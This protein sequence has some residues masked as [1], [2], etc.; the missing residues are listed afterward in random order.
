M[1]RIPS[2]LSVKPLWCSYTASD[3]PDCQPNL[4]LVCVCQVKRPLVGNVSHCNSYLWCPVGTRWRRPAARRFAPP[5]RTCGPTT[6]ASWARSHGTLNCRTSTATGSRSIPAP[7]R[8]NPS[9]RATRGLRLRNQSSPPL[10]KES[11]CTP[12]RSSLS[13]SSSSMW[14]IGPYTCD[15]LEM[16]LLTPPLHPHDVFIDLI[17]FRNFSKVDI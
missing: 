3:H 6:S 13:P 16:I 5:N 15:Y 9:P 17:V 2:L 11:T 10:P 1:T 8:A 4:L 14:F 7:L 12:G